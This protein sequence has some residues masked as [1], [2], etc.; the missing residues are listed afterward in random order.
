MDFQRRQKY[1]GIGMVPS[2]Y[3]VEILCVLIY[4]LLVRYSEL[5]LVSTIHLA[6]NNYSLIELVRA[7][8]Y[9]SRTGNQV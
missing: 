9:V 8:N 7:F 5:R 1:D 4:D 3:T 2:A 6:V